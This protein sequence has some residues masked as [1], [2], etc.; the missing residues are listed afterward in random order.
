M[1]RKGVWHT[2]RNIERN[3]GVI[4]WVHA[5]G[6]SQN[7]SELAALFPWVGASLKFTMFSGFVTEYPF[8]KFSTFGDPPFTPATRAGHFPS[9]SR[10]MADFYT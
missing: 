4:E 10:S 1:E 9:S 7:K 5:P 2:H 3:F 8:I 6:H